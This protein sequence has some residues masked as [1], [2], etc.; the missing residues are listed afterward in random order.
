MILIEYIINNYNTFA[1]NLIISL[2]ELFGW[3]RRRSSF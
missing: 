3:I 1:F 2:Y